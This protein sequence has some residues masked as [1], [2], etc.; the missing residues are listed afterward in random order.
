MDNVRNN[1]DKHI[2]E[3][4]SK[5]YYNKKFK[6]KKNKSKIITIFSRPQINNLKLTK[7]DMQRIKQK[8]LGKELIKFRKKLYPIFKSENLKLLNN[9]IKSLKVKI[10]YFD[11]KILSLKFSSGKYIL[12]KNKIILLNSFK[13]GAINH[14]FFHMAT[15]FYNEKLKIAYCGFQQI[16]FLKKQ[17][18]G[19]GLNE[20]YTELLTNRYF[21]EQIKLRSYSYDICTFFAEKLEEIVGKNE[22]EKFYISADLEGLYKYLTN[23]DTGTNISTFIVMLDYLV[24]HASHSYLSNS[25]KCEKYYE[26]IQCYLCKWFINKK[27]KE[28]NNNIINKDTY[29]KEIRKYINSLGNKELYLNNYIY[30]LRDKIKI[31]KK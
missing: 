1:I 30:F 6:L 27:Q 14:E 10:K 20:G 8:S 17:I 15:S 4:S 7:D 26:L 24:G 11:P 5:S 21:K 3:I 25:R 22:M 29:N 12:K 2:Q 28:L 31:Y 19:V 9:N 16:Y 23:F 13:E 18:I